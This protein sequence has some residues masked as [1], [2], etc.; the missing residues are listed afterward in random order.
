MRTALGPTAGNKVQSAL[1]FHSHGRRV[2]RPERK[3][4]KEP[5]SCNDRVMQISPACELAVVSSI[6]LNR[7]GVVI[8]TPQRE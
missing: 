2:P 4:K 6:R 5:L 3:H 8:V 1:N 7:T